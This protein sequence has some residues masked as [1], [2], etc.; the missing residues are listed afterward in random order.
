MF[1]DALILNEPLPVRFAGLIL[2]IVSQFTFLL[3]DHVRF[4]VTFTVVL[5]GAAPGFQALLDNLNTGRDCTVI[6][7][8]A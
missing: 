6:L 2:V 1:L 7:A 3:T 4:D 5:L 8:D